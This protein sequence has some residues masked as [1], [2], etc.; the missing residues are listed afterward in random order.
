MSPDRPNEHPIEEVSL[1][2][3]VQFA[4]QLQDIIPVNINE[5]T[6]EHPVEEVSPWLPLRLAVQL[7]NI[8]PVNIAA[9]RYPM[10]DI[11]DIASVVST[12]HTVI[13]LS[14]LEIDIETS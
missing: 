6:D 9:E 7:Q 4:V 3:P 13:N 8:I 14:E 5:H 1:W 11:T 2:S 10:D 12:A